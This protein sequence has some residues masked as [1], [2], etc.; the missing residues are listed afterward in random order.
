MTMFDC[1]S[2]ALGTRESAQQG[3]RQV[4]APL[5]A[6]PAMDATPAGEHPQDV[7]ETKVLPQAGINDLCAHMPT[8]GLPLGSEWTTQC[9]LP[10]LLKS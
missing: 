2:K 5:V 3:L 4:K 10:A 1:N 9:Q 7:Q 6:D 8:S